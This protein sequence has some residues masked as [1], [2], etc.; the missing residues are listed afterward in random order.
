[1]VKRTAA[2]KQDHTQLKYI[3]LAIGSYL[4]FDRANVDNASY[5]KFTQNLIYYITKLKSNAKY[6]SEMEIDIPDEA[7]SG[8]LRDE[9]I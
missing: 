6:I 9:V 1:M 4:T 7:D 5:E 3:N 2:S 8:I